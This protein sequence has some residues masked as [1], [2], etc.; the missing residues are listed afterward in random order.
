[1][2]NVLKH[3]V[4]VSQKI[5]K[6]P[7]YVQGGGGNISLKLNSN[8]MAIKASGFRLGDLAVDNGFVSVDHM[9]IN[10]FYRDIQGDENLNELIEKNARVVNESTLLQKGVLSLR[11]SIE[12]GFHALLGRC[13]VHTH[14]V[15]S[16]ILNCSVE[17]KKIIVELFP[18]AVFAPFGPPGVALTLGIRNAL[19]GSQTPIVFLE[20]HGLI[21]S[22]E[23]E[24][25][26]SDMHT[27]V[28]ARIK[29]KFG[30][31]EEYPMIAINKVDEESFLSDTPYLKQYILN[32]PEIVK[33]MQ[34]TILFPDQVVYSD[35]V[36]FDSDSPANIAIDLES[37]EIRYKTT[38]GEARA[39]E[40]TLA[41]WIFILDRINKIGLTIKTV[42]EAEGLFI[43]NMESEKY[44]KKMV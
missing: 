28:N 15:Y 7:E 16:N 21:V 26:V 19:A 33:N 23:T 3:I 34:H 8:E 2:N 5:G 11:P 30:I 17:G 36:G 12:T 25:E 14:S 44:R 9:K 10:D 13:V 18:E 42:S 20:N 43:S 31:D 37:G 27:L 39:F 41:S 6:Y 24:R 29:E 35:V 1:M 4:E 38:F 40:E 32:N 22:G